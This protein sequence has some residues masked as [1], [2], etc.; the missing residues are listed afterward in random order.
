MPC[1][2]TVWRIRGRIGRNPIAG[3][4]AS[5]LCLM[6][7]HSG[8]VQLRSDWERVAGH[9]LRMRKVWQVCLRQMNQCRVRSQA[10]WE[11]HEETDTRSTQ[12][13]AVHAVMP[14][15]IRHWSNLQEG[16]RNVH[17]GHLSCAYLPL[18][19][20]NAGEERAFFIELEEV[21][22]I[23]DVPVAQPVMQDIAEESLQDDELCAV[24]QMTMDGW[25][26]SRSSV[27]PLARPYYNFRDELTNLGA[28][29]F[30]GQYVVIPRSLR[31]LM[32]KKLRS[33]HLGTKGCLRR[34]RKVFYWPGMNREVKELISACHF[35]NTF[36]PEQCRG[37]LLP[38]E[39]PSHPWSRVGVDLFQLGDKLYLITLNYFSNFTEVDHLMTTT[40][41]QVINKL[42]IHFSMYG[43]LD[44]VVSDNG[45]HFSSEQFAA[46]AQQWQFTHMTS[47][48][49][50]P[51][52]NNKAENAVKTA[53]LIMKKAL[54][55]KSDVY[56]ALLDFRNTLREYMHSSPAQRMFGRCTGTLLPLSPSLL[57]PKP[58]QQ[59]TALKQLCRAKDK[60][61]QQY[62]HKSKPWASCSL[63]TLY[64]RSLLVGR[65]DAV[66][67]YGPLHELSSPWALTPTWLSV[68]VQHFA[69]TATNCALHWS[70][71][72]PHLCWRSSRTKS[73]EAHNLSHH[74]MTQ[75]TILSHVSL[76]CHKLQRSIFLPQLIILQTKPLQ[77]KQQWSHYVA[78]AA[79][80]PCLHT[81][82][83]FT[84]AELRI[85]NTRIVFVLFS[86]IVGFL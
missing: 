6:Y 33:S 84:C 28:L 15:E 80:R 1:N 30:K 10:T 76:A 25:L 38:H 29:L 60:Q 19:Q 16:H 85:T 48:P 40:S 61:A 45:P 5:H 41:T 9:C 69:R 8:R 13:L 70:S 31:P 66:Q 86:F 36:K 37:P 22:M 82:R 71:T 23:K 17:R 74:P 58:A 50:Y 7:T 55:S 21:N 75:L 47:S 39:I 62:N 49:H 43:I 63:E 72:R 54:E 78:A 27:V 81:T 51:Q 59:T 77:L 3:W 79:Q 53:K 2:D 4:K 11:H 83:T 14:A 65:T 26:N 67:T 64:E 32:M 57:Q 20:G 44:T 34:A 56:L 46:F 73:K 35:C 68:K 24:A 42:R 52:S 18:Q 12:T